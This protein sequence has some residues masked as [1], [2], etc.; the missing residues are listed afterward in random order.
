MGEGSEQIL[1]RECGRGKKR[2]KGV[3]E[4]ERERNI[5]REK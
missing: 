2:D 5:E 1:E 3:R 4:G